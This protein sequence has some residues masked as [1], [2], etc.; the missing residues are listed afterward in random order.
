MFEA[1]QFVQLAVVTDT[2]GLYIGGATS[3]T[4]KHCLAGQACGGT[5][6]GVDQG[7]EAV[8]PLA[9]GVRGYFL[10]GTGQFDGQG[11]GHEYGG[12]FYTPSIGWVNNCDGGRSHNFCDYR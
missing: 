2:N 7:A 10:Y 6:L 5:F 3:G 4:G 12:T 11:S 9:H 8:V 1:L